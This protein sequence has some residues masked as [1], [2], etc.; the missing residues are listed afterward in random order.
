MNKYSRKE[1]T[2]WL[3]TIVIAITITLFV[4]QGLI[5]N[6]T[7]PT[8][9]MSTTIEPGDRLI[10]NRLAYRGA[11]PER[12]EIVVFI[13]HEDEGKLYIKRLIGLPGETIQII[14]GVV[15]VDGIILIEPYLN[16]NLDNGNY[17]PYNVPE[18]YYFFLGD[19]RCNSKDSRLWKDPYIG[20]DDIVGKA[21][22][23]YFPVLDNL[24]D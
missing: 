7:V 8:T 17:G 3:K 2:G 11:D 10:A 4:N 24:T 6:A 16:E 12:G 19:N 13:Q 23:K 15:Y 18:D 21:I 22:F 20:T 9:S 14:D 1:V 5:V